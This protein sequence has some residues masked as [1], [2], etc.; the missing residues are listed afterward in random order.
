MKKSREQIYDELLVI[1]CRQSDKEAFSELVGRWQSR[2]WHYAYKV[3]GSE[4]AAWD[5]VQETWYSIIKGIRK[6]ND[7]SVFP[8][9]AFRIVN[10]KC[11]DWLRKNQL[12]NKLNTRLESQARDNT[13]Q[14]HDSDTKSESLRTAVEK[15][16]PE[17]RA[18]LELRYHEGFDIAQIAR[19]LDVPEGTVKSRLHRTIEQ[20]K[21]MVEQNRNE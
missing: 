8:H 20:L 4:P 1:R 11:S 18:L 17:R 19:I 10:S 21:Q 13:H 14:D 5:I 12:Q 7:V 9:W 2:L 15:L 6:L 16:P 3:T